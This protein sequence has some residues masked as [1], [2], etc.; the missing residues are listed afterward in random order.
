MA[1]LR[2]GTERKIVFPSHCPVCGDALVRPEGESVLRCVNINCEA[3]VLERLIHFGS[4]DAMDI[5]SLGEANVRRFYALGLLKD[6]PG[7]YHLDFEKIAQL[8]GFG[9]KSVD[10]LQ[11]AIDHSRKQPLHRLIYAL[12][13]RHVGETTAKTLAH[14]VK[15]MME[16]KGVTEERLLALADIGPKVASAI[17]EFFAN[18]DNIRMLEELKAAGVNMKGREEETA[19]LLSG[20]TF[21]F[22]GTLVS[23]KRSEAEALVEAQGG[24][25]LGSVS[26]KLNCLVTG[27]E[28]GSKIEKAKKIPT[29]RILTEEEFLK[30]TGGAGTA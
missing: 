13:I 23:L 3:Q 2:D 1:D 14:A 5:R 30:M 29:I 26:S 12:G 20:V 8:E 9:R 25:I 28:P 7:I 21:L 6:I 15:D 16:L 10:N 19:G 24:K 4:K 22:T 11:A 18:A 27:A 17:L